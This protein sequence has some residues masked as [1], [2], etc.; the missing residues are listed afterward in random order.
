M[1][2]CC[3][4]PP[5][6]SCTGR[7]IRRCNRWSAG[8]A[9]DPGDR[10][11]ARAGPGAIARD[12]RNLALRRRRSARVCG[13]RAGRSSSRAAIATRHVRPAPHRAGRR[14]TAAVLPPRPPACCAGRAR[15]ARATSRARAGDRRSRWPRPRLGAGCRSHPRNLRRKCRVRIDRFLGGGC[16][17][18]LTSASRTRFPSRSGTGHRRQRAAHDGGQFGVGTAVRSTRK[19][20]P[21]ATSCE[22]YAAVV[23]TSRWTARRRGHQALPTSASRSCGRWATRPSAACV[24]I[25]GLSAS[26]GVARD[27]QVEGL[28]RCAARSTRGAGGRA[29][30]VRVG[31]RLPVTATEVRV[32][33]R[34]PPRRLRSSRAVGRELFPFS[35]RA[36]A[37]GDRARRAGEGSRPGHGR[38]RCRALMHDEKGEE[39]QAYERLIGDALQGDATVH[40][41]GRGRGRVADRRP[42]PRSR[43]AAERLSRRYLGSGRSRQ[44]RRSRRL[45]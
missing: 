23:A 36:R 2:S 45:V 34:R 14:E 16:Q 26:P 39:M 5:V 33:L 21:S 29:V 32:E 12:A 7:S 41:P 27:S 10:C 40:A 35:S 31:K 4:A 24:D 17:N 44:G 37:H 30:L 22:P 18:L 38:R 25:R 3:S 8:A 20:A 15:A 13:A 19:W 42:H 43:T 28:R 11:R 6:T 9:R 1:R